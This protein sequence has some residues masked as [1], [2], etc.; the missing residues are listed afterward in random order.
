MHQTLKDLW[1]VG[2]IPCETVREVFELTAATVGDVVSCMPDGEIGDRTYW[3]N[4]LC[5]RVYNG[6]P[7]IETLQRPRP[8][9]GCPQW[10]PRG[11][12]DNWIFRLRPGV[13]TLRFPDLGYAEFALNSYAMFGLLRETGRIPADMKLLVCLPFTGSGIDCFFHEPS[14]YPRLHAAY[15]E[16]MRRDIARMLA[17]IP[18]RDLVIQWDVCIEVLD[19]EGFFPWTP[20]ENRF[21][22][23][24]AAIARMADAIPADVGVGYHWC[25]GT[26]GGWPMKPPESLQLCVDLSNA[27]ARRSGRPVDFMHMPVPRHCDE[28]F[29]APLR[30]LDVGSTKIYLGLIHDSDD[31]AANVA[32]ATLARRFLPR[33]GVSSVCGYGR[34]PPEEMPRILRLHRDVVGALAH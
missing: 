10:K 33:F 15:E 2:S 32:R 5:Y 6:H 17:H 7:D 13:E 34:C 30:A 4:Y 31:V 20:R 8:I 22:R 18:A 27:A 26:L 23:N 19:I 16:A 12:A 3:V 14:D 9:D 1:L 28:A 29:V 11:M 21:A 25:Y 24:T